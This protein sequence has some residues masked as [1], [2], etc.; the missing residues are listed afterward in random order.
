MMSEF[1][2]VAMNDTAVEKC[3]AFLTKQTNELPEV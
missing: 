3:R 1:A 2:A